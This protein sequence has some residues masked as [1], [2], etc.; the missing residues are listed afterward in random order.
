MALAR[1]I[2]VTGKGGT[3]KS[4]V[5][6]ALALCLARR[7]PTVLVD[8]D[9][10]MW[11]ARMLGL[12]SDG[13]D[14]GD[15]RG[16]RGNGEA[17][18]ANPHAT[19]NPEAIANLETMSLSAATELE[20]FIE[21]IVPIKAVARRMLQSRT[22]GYVSA[23]LPGLE[24]FLM[25]ERLRIIAG[26][27]ALED[28]YAVVDAPASGSALE[29]LSVPGALRQIAPL[30]TLNRLAANVESFLVD[31]TRFAV[32]LTLTPQELALREA[33]EA[34][35]VLRGRLGVSVAAAALNR[36]PHRLFNQRELDALDTYPEGALLARWR[37]GAGGFA[38][39]ARR[40]ASRAGLGVIELPMLFS[41]AMGRAELQELSRALDA[42]LFPLKS[43]KSA[44]SARSSES[45]KSAKPPTPTRPPT[46]AK[47]ARIASAVKL[48]GSAKFDRPQ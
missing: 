38:A 32:M 7:R 35:D 36:V 11:A 10:R 6:A 42:R 2:L 43:G 30:G 34:S 13:R 1:L 18:I 23:A 45:G 19:A 14:A 24:A 27:A 28:R 8:L 12:V 47:P 39:R 37:D 33:L 40:E 21:R 26:R 20:A 41:P 48:P 44:K 5:A 16:P 15:D 9:Q 31:A 4:A 3:G 22:F 29:L 46:S 17:A 25:L